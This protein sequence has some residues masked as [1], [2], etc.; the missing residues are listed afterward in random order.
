M[1]A[2]YLQHRHTGRA[3]RL[4][5]VAG[6]L[7]RLLTAYH[8][9]RAVVPGIPVLLADSGDEGLRLLLVSDPGE[10]ADEPGL[11]DLDLMGA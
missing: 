7:T 11:L 5:V 6:A 3:T 1:P 8:E 4:A 10:V 9:G 2:K